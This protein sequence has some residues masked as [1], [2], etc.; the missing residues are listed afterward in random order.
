MATR[1]SAVELAAHGLVHPKQ[2][3]RMVE[4]GSDA[5]ALSRPAAII[6]VASDGGP[7]RT[8]VGDNHHHFV[9]EEHSQKTGFSN[10]YEG[11]TE[12]ALIQESEL[13]ADVLK[14]RTQAYRISYIHMGQREQWICDHLRHIRVNGV[15]IVE[16]IECKPNMSYLGDVAERSRFNTLARILA[17]LGQKFRVVYEDGVKGGGE[18]QLNFGQ[19]YTH[20]TVHV[21]HDAMDRFERLVL[22]T[23]DLAFGALAKALHPSRVKGEAM[24]HA[25]I[26]LGRVS[27]D[28][29]HYLFGGSPVRLLPEPEFT[30]LIDF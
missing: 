5:A 9:G 18:R 27:I 20:R 14:Y 11:A 21:P 28:L 8:I 30:S 12:Y 25:L 26:C 10:P 17:G 3:L 15:D 4:A 19:I 23:P 1:T 13:R 7:L 6:H 22:D 24:A 29:D 2:R 16:A